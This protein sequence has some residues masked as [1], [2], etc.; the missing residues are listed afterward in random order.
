VIGDV[1]AARD[2]A[3]LSPAL[4]LTLAAVS[5]LN[6]K[7]CGRFVDW[8]VGCMSVASSLSLQRLISENNPLCRSGYRIISR[9]DAALPLALSLSL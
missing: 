1:M 4:S 2:D 9:D 6:L 3:A 7:S 8:Y 5:S